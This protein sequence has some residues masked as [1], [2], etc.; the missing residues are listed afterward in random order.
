MTPG[1]TL[2]RPGSVFLSYTRG[3][4]DVAG[5]VTNVFEPLL[6]DHLRRNGV[7][8]PLSVFR[9]ETSLKPGE[10][11]PA[12]LQ[13]ALRAADVLVPI[14]TPEYFT[15]PWCAAEFWTMYERQR[16][17]F[18]CLVPVRF[19]DG[20]FFPEEARGLGWYDM[21]PRR[22]FSHACVRSRH[23]APK[24]FIDLIDRM[25]QVIADRVSDQPP[26]DPGWR[27]ASRPSEP[28]GGLAQPTWPEHDQE[29]EA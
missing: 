18:A 8:G 12:A 21:Q 4:A 29:G 23:Q 25:S 17:G 15:R 7:T 2:T 26:E 14:F 24:G 20:D 27:M 22:G 16:R 3:P 6:V 1:R 9:D 5:W 28:A 11:W 10:P 13:E 19:S